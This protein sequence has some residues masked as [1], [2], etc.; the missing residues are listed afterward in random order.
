MSE[1]RKEEMKW[2][3]D[4]KNMILR[5]DLTKKWILN[6]YKKG[7]FGGIKNGYKIFWIHRYKY[8]IYG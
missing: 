7:N 1:N 5:I 3:A 8:R 4:L 6:N 2:K